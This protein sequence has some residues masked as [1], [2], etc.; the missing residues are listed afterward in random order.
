MSRTA[1]YV[2]FDE[3]IRTIFTD[4]ERAQMLPELDL[5]DWRQ[6]RDKHEIVRDNLSQGNI[7]KSYEREITMTLFEAWMDDRGPKRRTSA[8]SA[9]FISLDRATEYW[10]LYQ[11]PEGGKYMDAA[12]AIINETRAKYKEIALAASD[13]ERAEKLDELKNIAGQDPLRSQIA[14]IDGL[15]KSLMLDHFGDGNGGLDTASYAE[16]VEYFGTDE[17]ALDL[18]RHHLVVDPGDFRRKYALYHRM[19]G[20]ELWFF[21]CAYFQAALL[22]LEDDEG[23]SRKCRQ[24]G[25]ACAA[26]GSAFDYAFRTRGATRPDYSD[27]FETRLEL[28]RRMSAFSNAETT[29]PAEKEATDL[30]KIYLEE[31]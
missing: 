28:K 20:Q 9:F 4:E 27:N 10:N 18:H 26:V 30:Y 16:A 24:T 5:F 7:G 14:L 23:I 11:F 29:E 8:Y 6:V 2:G 12:I 13:A 3:D 31:S 17:L 19:D 1:G 21:W 15:L 25:L 22:V